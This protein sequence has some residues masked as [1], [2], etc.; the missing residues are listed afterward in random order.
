[1]PYEVSLDDPPAGK[2]SILLNI[3]MCNSLNIDCKIVS[4]ALVLFYIIM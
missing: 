3:V 2:R 4:H 1:M